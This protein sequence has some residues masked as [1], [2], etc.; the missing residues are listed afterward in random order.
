MTTKMSKKNEKGVDKK[1]DDDKDLKKKP[2]EEDDETTDDEIDEEADDEEADDESD[3]DEGEDDD[4]DGD[5][6]SKTIDYKA[7][8]EAEKQKRKKA[9]ALIAHDKFKKK[10]SKD[11]DEADDEGVDDEDKPV[12]KRELAQFLSQSS[13]RTNDAVQADR[14]NEI[15]NRLSDSPEEADAI[16]ATHTN[17]TWPDDVSLTEQLEEAH[18]IV[19]RKRNIS[20]LSEMKR[21]LGSKYN[22]S[23]GD[24]DTQRDS[25]RGNAPKMSKADSLAY[26]S[27]GFK[28]D[29][30]S[31]LYRKKL[32]NG[33]FLNKDPKTKKS[34]VK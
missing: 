8:A 9:E 11:E 3:D 15:A 5:G 31:G 24:A 30:K 23:K 25:Q 2:I 22:T 28:F 7:I 13:K 20:K 26:A 10:H 12:T 19:N 18:A 32:P 4:D 6:S 33:T 16:I 29:V 14:I 34:W 21:A 27:A 17:R 1:S